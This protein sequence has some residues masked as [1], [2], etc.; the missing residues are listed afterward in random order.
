MRKQLLKFVIIVKL[1]NIPLYC[2][3]NRT[4]VS[5]LRLK[6]S[7]LRLSVP[8]KSHSLELLLKSCISI[9]LLEIY[10]ITAVVKG[11]NTIELKDNLKKSPVNKLAF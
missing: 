5:L 11:I 4:P 2:L 1:S 9:E 8:E 10:I 6:L 3:K 7:R